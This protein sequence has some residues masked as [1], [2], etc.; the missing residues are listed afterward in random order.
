MLGVAINTRIHPIINI[1]KRKHKFFLIPQRFYL[2]CLVLFCLRVAKFFV[3]QFSCIR[4]SNCKKIRKGDKNMMNTTIN[5][6]GYQANNLTFGKFDKARR[7]L[8]CTFREILTV[9]PAAGAAY[10]HT[11]GAQGTWGAA[12]TAGITTFVTKFIVGYG[13]LL[14][15]ELGWIRKVSPLNLPQL[16]VNGTERVGEG[17]ERVLDR[18]AA[19]IRASKK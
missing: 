15:E 3:D 13:G 9:G 2:S 11:V 10:A 1:K 4:H 17:F 6:A 12:V 14:A 19:K 7:F 8:N 5:R 18:L 16:L